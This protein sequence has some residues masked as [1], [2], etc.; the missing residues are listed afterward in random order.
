MPNI[1][2]SILLLL[3]LLFILSWFF[4]LLFEG[5]GVFRC[6]LKRVVEVTDFGVVDQGMDI[7]CFLVVCHQRGEDY[8]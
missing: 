2:R 3:V 7:V 8:A 1:F 4:L 6:A 5:V